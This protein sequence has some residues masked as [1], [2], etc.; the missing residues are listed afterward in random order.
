MN[1]PETIQIMLTGIAAVGSLLCLAVLLGIGRQIERSFA[2]IDGSG[3]EGGMVAALND[4][5][6]RDDRSD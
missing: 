2:G 6:D 3:F 4:G 1:W 5:L